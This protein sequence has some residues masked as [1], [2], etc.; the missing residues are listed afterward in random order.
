MNWLAGKAPSHKANDWE[1]SHVLDAGATPLLHQR[2]VMC[3]GLRKAQGDP[4]SST[5]R[6]PC[7]CPLL[8]ALGTLWRSPRRWGP[9]AGTGQWKSHWLLLQE[10]ENRVLSFGGGSQKGWRRTSTASPT[11]THLLP[12][13]F[14]RR[15]NMPKRPYLILW[16]L[17][18][19]T[20]MLLFLQHLI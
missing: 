7:P 9:G 14:L 5:L 13:F 17:C 6:L 18:I 4:S 12:S 11:L 19:Y 3:S 20:H 15:T 8:P 10:E 1:P 16:N 2:Q